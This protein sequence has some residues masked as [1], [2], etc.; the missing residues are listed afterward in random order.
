LIETRSDLTTTT[1]ETIFRSEYDTRTR[2]DLSMTLQRIQELPVKIRKTWKTQELPVQTRETWKP[3]A[4]GAN[5][6]DL[7]DPGASGANPGDLAIR[8]IWHP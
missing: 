7:D 2:F 5:P 6:G 1:I 4:S 8:F 3:G